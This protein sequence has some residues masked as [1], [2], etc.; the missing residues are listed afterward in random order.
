MSYH[1][2]TGNEKIELPST[3]SLSNGR[4]VRMEGNVRFVR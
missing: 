4:A 2:V 3:P 1:G